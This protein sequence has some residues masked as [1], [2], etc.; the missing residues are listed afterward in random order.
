MNINCAI[1]DDEKIIC[2]ELKLFLSELRPNYNIDVFHSGEYLINSQK[3]F[4]LIFLDI[5]MPEID[6]MKTAEILRKNDNTTT[7][8]VF[9]TNHIELMPEAFNVRAFR[10]II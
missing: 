5:E 3:K 1:C 7:Y 8:I 10:I 6:A 4:D 2:N 9:I